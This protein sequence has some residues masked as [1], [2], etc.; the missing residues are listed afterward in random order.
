[1]AIEDLT[2]IGS[3]ALDGTGNMYRNRISGNDADNILNGAGGNDRLNGGG[4]DDTLYGSTGAAWESDG[5]DKLYGGAGADSFMMQ[6]YPF[7]SEDFI[8][9]F[10]SEDDTIYLNR[11]WFSTVP[12]GT[13]AADAFHEGSS[14]EDPEDRIIYNRETGE[15]FW[16]R[17]GSGGGA[18]LFLK[19]QPNTDLDHTDFVAYGG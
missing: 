19:V 12:E 14:A 8:G 13:L 1:M 7:F 15:I 16:D 4:G 9:D 17:D 6:E 2:L 11:E 3:A 18:H 10:T 5:F